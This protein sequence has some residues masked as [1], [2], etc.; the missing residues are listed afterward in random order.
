[1]TIHLTVIFDD[2][3]RDLALRLQG[4]LSYRFGPGVELESFD[5]NEPTDDEAAI[6]VLTLLS[7]DNE[8]NRQVDELVA[9]G[10]PRDEVMSEL[11]RIVVAGGALALLERDPTPPRGTAR[12]VANSDPP[13]MPK[14]TD[15][16]ALARQIKGR[17]IAE[18]ACPE[19]SAPVG[20]NCRSPSGNQYGL[21]HT[22]M[23][24]IEAFYAAHSVA[25]TP[26]QTW[27]EINK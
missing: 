21:V 14:S 5:E 11:N 15:K 1:M 4:E 9:T 7:R 17:V 8:L 6:D 27:V 2:D 13:P 26:A 23:A 10:V 12:L 3:D 20:S 22:H 18:I 16:S 19:C 24:R 25:R